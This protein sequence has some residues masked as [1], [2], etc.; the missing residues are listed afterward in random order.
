MKKPK[1][2]HHLQEDPI[3]HIQLDAKK[4]ADPI[5]HQVLPRDLLQASHQLQYCQLRHH[6]QQQPQHCQCL[7]KVK[8]QI[9]R[10]KMGHTLQVK[11][12]YT[13]VR[14]EIDLYFQSR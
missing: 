13:K 8:T 10:Q 4:S 7:K 14:P 6:P 12:I 2:V 3:I 5:H 11:V 9:A 1:V